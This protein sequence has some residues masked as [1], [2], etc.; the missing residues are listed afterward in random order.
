MKPETASVEHD[1]IV[2]GAGA[3]GGWAA[4]QLTECGQRVLLID[5]GP[6]RDFKA[7]L[8]RLRGAASAARQPIQSRCLVFNEDNRHYFVDDV[9]NPYAV[10]AG[11]P[12]DWIRCRGFGG[13]TTVWNRIALRMSDYQLKAAD[14]DDEGVN[15][16]V[17]YRELAPYYDRI[18]RY[19][20]LTGI[21]EGHPEIPDGRYSSP[22]ELTASERRFK[23]AVEAR[24]PERRV[25]AARQIGFAVPGPRSRDAAAGLLFSVGVNAIADAKRTG[26]LTTRPDAVISAVLMD[27]V[28]GLARGVEFVDRWTKKTHRVHG[29]TV[30]LCASALE[31]TRILLNSSTARFPHGLANSSGVLGR[32]L[33]DHVAGVSVEGRIRASSELP[34]AGHHLYIP[35]FRNRTEKQKH[36]LRGYGASVKVGYRWP[37]RRN[38]SGCSIHFFGEMLPRKTNRVTLRRNACDAWG[39]PTLRIECA[40]SRNERRMA[41]DQAAAGYEMLAAAGYQVV[42]ISPRPGPPGSAHHEM[43]TAR[44][45]GDRRTS[46]LNRFN[47]CWDVPNLF[48]TDGAAFPSSGFQNPTLTMLALTAR[49]CDA[50]VRKRRPAARAV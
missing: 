30:I 20:G 22:R 25:T 28:R 38:W 33:M 1:A 9:D 40:H 37:G 31:S 16:P 32:Y 24:W 17:S 49:A 42:S 46:V 11:K 4:K 18:E 14:H 13:R 35:N 15:W 21:A 44:M 3:C 10:P 29:R 26:R 19:Y 8:Q 47:Q 50:I 41:A 36:F 12:F 6:D 39:V 45:G 48:V 43:G 34:G 5:A 23:D 2:I 27:E 7:E